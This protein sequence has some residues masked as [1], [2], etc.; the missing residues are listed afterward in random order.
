M[1]QPRATS[2]P[3]LTVRGSSPQDQIEWAHECGYSHVGLRFLPVVEGEHLSPLV[4]HPDR[5]A[6]IKGRLNETGIKV[7][8]IEF[9]WLKPNTA[10]RDFEPY[11]ETAALLGAQSIL[12]GAND[13]DQSR[14]ATRWLELCELAACYGLRAHVEFIPFPSMT[15][16]NTYAQCIELMA[17]VPHRSAGLVIDALHFARS[18]GKLS[19]IRREHS[20]YM[21]YMQLCDAPAGPVSI[22]EAQRQARSDRLPPGRGGLDLIGLLKALPADLPLSLEVPLGGAAQNWPMRHKVKLV[23]DATQELL[24]RLDESISSA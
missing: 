4:G 13:S 24:T 10:V 21:T 7:L 9:F 14:L 16:L 5:I 23:H 1:P 19:E 3:Y 2:L 22:E 17:K 12:A 20:I 6:Q 18:G 11:I 15:T 8:D